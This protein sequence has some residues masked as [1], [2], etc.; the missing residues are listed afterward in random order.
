MEEKILE[1]L[2]EQTEAGK[3]TYSDVNK[4]LE[5]LRKKMIQKLLDKEFEEHMKYK[6]GSHEETSPTRSLPRGTRKNPLG[7]AITFVGSF[8]SVTKTYKT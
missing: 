3:T 6:K 4:M 7:S 5:D 2:M 8:K 1:M